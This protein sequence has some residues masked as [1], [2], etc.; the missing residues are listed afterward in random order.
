M[1]SSAEALPKDFV[2]P[3]WDA[4]ILSV[5]QAI[6]D[7]ARHAT[8]I[9]RL[10]MG[11]PRI[12]VLLVVDGMNREEVDAHC[13]L[14]EHFRREVRLTSLAPSAT[15]PIITSIVT[16][17]PP[18]EHGAT[19]WITWCREVG[20]LILPLP[21]IYQAGGDL[22]SSGHSPA[23]LLH[24]G[25]SLFEQIAAT[26]GRECFQIMPR[27]IAGSAFT[28]GMQRGAKLFPFAGVPHLF[29]TIEWV[30]RWIA[31]SKS[32]RAFV[33]AYTDA[34]DQ[35]QHRFG[36]SDPNTHRAYAE[37]GKGLKAL[38][39]SLHGKDVAILALSDHGFVDCPPEE[40]VFLEDHPALAATL[41]LPLSGEPRFA[42]CHLKAGMEDAFLDYVADRLS[43]KFFA[44]ATDP[45]RV[46]DL[47]GNGPEHREFGDRI[48]DFILAAKGGAAIHDPLANEPLKAFRGLHGSLLEAE[49]L[50]PLIVI[51]P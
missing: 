16:G 8:L 23:R 3:D 39:R 2:L 18:R 14:G 29:E 19:G 10:Q 26:T 4:N 21:F 20:A 38:A 24:D 17:L 31:T 47:F 12:L 46:R 42:Y 5:L 25:P 11:D 7:P 28:R 34:L 1:S 13:E 48:G 36:I 45:G 32:R 43:G 27:G 41:R 30:V 37:I 51:R 9:E 44:I 15:A 6:I 49:M 22:A 40:A 33:Y 35:T 50:I